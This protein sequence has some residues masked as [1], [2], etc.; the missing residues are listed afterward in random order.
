MKQIITP[1]SRLFLPSLDKV[2]I[3]AL[4]LGAEVSDEVFREQR[5]RSWNR[6][7]TPNTYALNRNSS[8]TETGIRRFR[9]PSMRTLC[10]RAIRANPLVGR[11]NPTDHATLQTCHMER[12]ERTV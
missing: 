8:E 7:P 2:P 12:V 3:H 6:G 4:V 5:Q 9:R 11:R 1:L 10:H